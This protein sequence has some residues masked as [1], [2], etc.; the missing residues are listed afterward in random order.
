LLRVLKLYIVVNDKHIYQLKEQQP[1]VIEENNLPIKIVAENS[2]HFSKPLIIK[3]YSH[4]PILIG[5]GCEVDNG[6]LWGGLLFSALLFTVFFVTR[7]YLLLLLANL[8]LVFLFYK[9]FLNPKAFI[10]IEILKK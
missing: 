2:F 8:P 3:K 5:I 10:T 4:S 1:L 9:Y 7:F 6:R